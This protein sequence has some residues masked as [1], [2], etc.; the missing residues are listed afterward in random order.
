VRQDPLLEVPAGVLQMIAAWCKSRGGKSELHRATQGLTALR[1][2]ARNS[3]TE[4]ISEAMI[5]Q[6]G[7]GAC[8]GAGGV[9]TAKLCVK[10][11]QIGNHE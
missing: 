6:A 2:K 7:T 1:R 11:D 10:Q 5:Q 9:K 3:G 4:R 8:R